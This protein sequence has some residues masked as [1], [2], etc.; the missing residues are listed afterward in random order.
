MALQF[1]SGKGTSRGPRKNFLEVG[2]MLPTA[3]ER[4]KVCSIHGTEVALKTSR[5]LFLC[6]ITGIL[7]Y[8]VYSSLIHIVL[9]STGRGAV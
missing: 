6:G 2:S 9:G 5:N 4:V 1:R 7:L 3:H 8:I